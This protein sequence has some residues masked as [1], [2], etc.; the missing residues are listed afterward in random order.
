MTGARELRGR[1]KSVEA[2][3]KITNAMF[4]ISS[5]ALRKARAQLR[6]NYPYFQR[7]HSTISDILQHSSQLNHPYFDTRPH[8]TAAE[9]TVGLVVITG[10]KGLAGAYNHNVLK[11]AEK[12]LSALSHPRLYLV[13]Q[14]GRNWFSGKESFDVAQVAYSAQNPDL[15]RARQL[16]ELLLDAFTKG[17]LDE[18][19]MI[20]TNM[21]SPLQLEPTVTKLLPLERD[22]FPESN[23]RKDIYERTVVYHPSAETV[24]ERL[25]PGYLS[26]MLFGA[27]VESYCSEQSARMMAMDL[28]SKNATDMLKDLQLRYNRARQAAITQEITEVVGGAA[29]GHL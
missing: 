21:A 24:M 15:K 8:L 19:W 22:L 16:G 18:V 1:I 3:L 9:R 10:D 25:V 14:M 6:S 13:G 28:S 7:L 29:A 17:D 27:L 12:K 11:L 2:T 26:G 23:D 4:L 5:T 20:Y